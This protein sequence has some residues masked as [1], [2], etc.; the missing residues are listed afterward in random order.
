M[1]IN[2]N[3]DNVVAI[4]Q[5]KEFLKLNKEGAGFA[6][7]NKQERNLWIAKTL[8]KFGYFKCRKKEKIIIKNYIKEM[9]GLSKMQIKKLI[10]KKRKFGV[11]NFESGKRNRFARKYNAADIALLI[12]TDNF[13][14]RL[15]GPATKKILIREY[16]I[17][18]KK[19]YKNIKDISVSHL[20]NL[21]GT[22]QYVSHSLTVRKTNPTKVL[23][24]QRMKPDNHG[25]PG[26]LR[27]D[28]VHQGDLDKEKGVYHINIVDEVTQWEIIGC[29]EKI[30]EEY[31][32]PLLAALLEQFPFLIINFHSDNGSEFINRQ[33]AE[34]LNR[35]MIKQTKS[36]ARRHNDNAL[37]EGKN[38]CSIRKNIGYRFIGKEYAPI[39]NKFYKEFFNPYLNY[40]RPCGYA[41]ITTDKKGKEKKKYDTYQM[42]YERLK[43][44]PAAEKYLKPGIT[45]SMLDEIAYAQSDNEFGQKMQDKKVELFNSFKTSKLQFPTIFLSRAPVTI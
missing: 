14:N 38:N 21:R 9:T 23:I 20:Y 18:H 6:A 42:P 8:D 25:I 44:L 36:R 40:H 17:F 1:T 37:A 5:I 41:T 11:I 10:R 4:D 24:G 26:F 2:M 7:A 13:H 15:S 30:S 39:I 31:L 22:R 29:V 12:K 34:M 45:F 19:E 35:M 33:V 27:V 16:E 32:L 43:S 3:D 28:T